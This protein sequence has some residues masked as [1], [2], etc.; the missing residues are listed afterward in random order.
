MEL[1][2]EKLPI[3]VGII[4][5][6]NGRWAKQKG[7]PRAIGHRA[8]TERLQ[9]IVKKT[10]DLGIGYL[11]VYA[12]STENWKRPKAEVET[13]MELLREY[14]EKEIEELH[15]NHVCIRILGEL[16]G[17]PE[18]IRK[19][20]CAAMEKTAGNSGL[21]FNIAFNYGGRA[22]AAYAARKLA[23][24][25]LDGVL[26]LDDIDEKALMTHLYTKNQP[27]VDLV[28][29]TSGEERL[30]N[31]MPL[32]AAYA[33]LYFTD[34]YWPDFSDEEYIRALADFAARDRRYGGIE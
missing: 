6:G 22:E 24:E 10:S 26:T 21:N 11:T 16:S 8:G 4:M 13:L 34:V 14:F 9:G 32:Q 23:M 17:L 15:K 2:P 3:H 33:E 25:L 29:R 19:L 18:G 7:L 27:D 30:S 12:F 20:L 1:N 28:I 5:D 31:F